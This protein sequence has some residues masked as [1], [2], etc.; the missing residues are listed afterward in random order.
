M[1]NMVLKTQTKSTIKRKTHFLLDYA[2]GLCSNEEDI[3]GNL[4]EKKI[5]TVN[6]GVT[7]TGPL[8]SLGI[9]KEF[10]QYLKPQNVI[11]L[12]FEG[13]DLEDLNSKKMRIIY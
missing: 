11:Y 13:N 8:V 10:G 6:F 12:Y 9:L 1:I 7:D 3:A 5:N 4:I 2:E